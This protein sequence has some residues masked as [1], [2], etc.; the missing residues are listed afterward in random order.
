MQVVIGCDLHP[1]VRQSMVLILLLKP[2]ALMHGSRSPRFIHLL[3]SLVYS[4]PSAFLSH[5]AVLAFI[6]S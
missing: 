4:R 5:L 1:G 3:L 2:T 6:R